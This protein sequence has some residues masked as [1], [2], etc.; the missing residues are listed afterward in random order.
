M[1]LKQGLLGLLMLDKSSGYDLY[2]CVNV[3]I[4]YFWKSSISQVYR[5]LEKMEKDGFVKSTR[6]TQD[7]KPNKRIYEITQTG[8]ELHNNWLKEYDISK[9]F[10]YRIGILMW[11]YF[12]YNSPREEIIKVLENYYVASATNLENLKELINSPFYD[13]SKNMKTYQNATIKY[14][15]KFHEMLKEWCLETIED[16]KNELEHNEKNDQ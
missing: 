7:D 14:G 16:I 3:S 10:E 6:V 15:I 1:S 8:I 5:D 12:S 13:P 2:D 9:D 4:G 11:T